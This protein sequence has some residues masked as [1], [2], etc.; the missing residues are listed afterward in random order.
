MTKRL[1]FIGLDGLGLDLAQS[2]AQR[3]VMPHLARLME[4]GAA[5]GTDSPLPEVSPVCW[6]S[7]FSGAEPGAHGVYGFGVPE[8]G[9]YRVRPVEAGDVAA[10]RLWEELSGLGRASVVLN[11][12]LTY[13]ARAIRGAMVSGFVAPELTRAVYPPELLPRLMALG[14][15]PE[16]DLEAGV[17]DPAAL[18]ADLGRAIEARAALFSQFWDADWDLYV[19][20]FTD[21][22]RVNHFLWPALFDPGHPLSGPALGLYRAMDDFLGALWRRFGPEVE[23][24]RVALMV[25]A[26]H[27]F[28]PIRSEVYLNPWLRQQGFLRV[29]GWQEGPGRMRILPGS[30]ALALDPGRV[31]LHWAGRFPG[32][33]LT[34]GPE[35]E[36]A[37]RAMRQG[38]LDLRFSRV[39][40]QD[41]R[42]VV[43]QEAPISQAHLGRELYHGP[44]AHLAPDLVAVAAPGYCLRAGLGRENVFGLS[45][46]TGTHR[47]QGALACCLPRPA[48]PLPSRV[49]GVH[50]LMRALLG[51]ASGQGLVDRLGHMA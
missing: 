3:G 33:H 47:P 18:V 15:R 40:M 5:W 34:P 13:P 19:A 14:Y 42:P 46:L 2:L 43:S 23:A 8:P 25:A 24:G 4:M 22:D 45:H 41:G 50:G 1:I 7:L 9:A 16:A 32:G 49:S 35:A 20:V 37:L 10:P 21:S 36:R 26:D 38:L 29:E 6:T 12:P 28:G 17:D 51:L 39:R 48:G 31:Y 27:A 44:Q 11:V 30:L